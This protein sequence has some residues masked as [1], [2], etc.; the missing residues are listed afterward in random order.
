MLHFRSSK[1]LHKVKFPSPGVSDV[2]FA[3]PK[4]N[5]VYVISTRVLVNEFGGGIAANRTQDT[6]F[7]RVKGLNAC[8]YETPRIRLGG[9]GK[10][11]H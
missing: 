9:K 7:F 8:G 5:E 3:G 1:I 4:L 11:C 2:V 10:K 6:V